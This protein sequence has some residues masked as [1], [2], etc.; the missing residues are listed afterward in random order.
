[1]DGVPMASHKPSFEVG[2]ERGLFASRWLMAPM[3]L[4]LVAAL[5]GMV[6]IFLRELLYYL[7]QFMTISADGAILAALTLIDLTLAA[8]LMCIVIYTGYENF[9]SKMDLPEDAERPSWMGT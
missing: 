7:P 3:Y 5:F 4:G 2:L 6:V 1:I 8:N 9:V